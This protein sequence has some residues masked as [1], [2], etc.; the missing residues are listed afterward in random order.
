MSWLNLTI[1]QFHQSNLTGITLA[2]SE[3]VTLNLH[4]P[5][6]RMGGQTPCQLNKYTESQ[7][8]TAWHLLHRLVKAVPHD[9]S[10]DPFTVLWRAAS[11]Q[12]IN[13]PSQEVAHG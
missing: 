4:A 2:L 5:T 9:H 3:P 7:D 8:S 1:K 11:R 13:P 12:G 6:D 10:F